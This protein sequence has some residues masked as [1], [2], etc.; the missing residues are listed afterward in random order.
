MAAFVARRHRRRWERATGLAI[1]LGLVAVAVHFAA[2]GASATPGATENEPTT[3]VLD[4]FQRPDEA[5]LRQGGNWA[6]ASIDGSGPTL[7]VLGGSAGQDEG[8]VH[9]DSYRSADLPPGDAEVYG[10]IAVAPSDQRWMQLYLHL[11]EAGTPG[12]D[13]YEVRWFHWVA[14]DG[15]YLRKIV[16]GVSTNLPGSP[17][18]I[19][20]A[21]EPRAGDILLFRRVGGS[22]QFWHK[23]AGTWFLRLSA[24]DSSY[25]G[26]KIGLGTDGTKARWDDFGGSGPGAPPPPPPPP[27]GTP[28]LDRSRGICGGTGV[29]AIATSRCLSDPVNTLTGAFITSADDLSVPGAGIAFAWSRSYTSSD[30]TSGRLGPGWTDGYATSLEIEADGDAR[31]HGDEGQIVAYAKQ[32]DGSFVGAPGSLSVLSAVPGGYQLARTDQVVYRFD[33]VGRLLSTKDRNGQGLTFAYDGAGR[34]STVTDAAGR[35]G[36]LTYNPASLVTGVSTEDGRSVA[37]GYADGRLTSFTDV[38]GKTWR[39]SYDAAGRLATIVD[40]LDH[41]QV[42][43]AYGADGRIQS[44]TDALGK[45]TAFAWD[46]TTQTA[47]ATDANGNAWKDD[48]AENVLVARVDPLGNATEFEHDDGLNMSG[49]TSP[50]GETTSLTHDAHGNVLTATGSASLGGARKSFAYNARNDPTQVTDAR[51]VVTSYAYDSEGNTEGVVQDGTQVASYT[52]D[53]VGRVLTS[54]DGN[55]QTTS[56]T[57]DSNGNVGS[58]TDP[59]GN[60]TTYTYD[61]AGRV[62]SRVDPRGNVAGANPADFTWRW[63]YNA[64]GQVLTERNPLG[65]VTTHTYDDAGNELSVTDA[66]GR[67]TTFAYDAANR[68]TSEEGPAPDAAGPLPARVTTYVYDDVGNR[69]SETDAL[70]RTTT[71]AYD[72]AN[73]HVSTTAPD[74]DG[75]GPLSAPVT[76]SLYDENGN[77][78]STVEPRGNV[79]GA[80]PNDFRT[81][82]TYD[83]A[84]RLLSTT[85][86]L[87]NAATNSYDP[88]GNLVST[89]DANGRATTTAYDGSGRILR[90]TGADGGVTAYTY[91]AVGNRLTRTD[92]NGHVTSYAYDGA[93]QLVAE[94]GPDPDGPGPNGPA[95]TTHTYDPNGNLATTVDA[96]GN[97][98]PTAGDGRTARAYDASNRLVAIDYSDSTPDVAFAYD[99]VGNR[100]SMT[101]GSGTETRAYD[102]LSRLTSVTRGSNTFCVSLRRRRQS[103]ASNVSGRHGDRLLVRR[104][105]PTVRRHRRGPDDELRLRR[106]V[107]PDAD[108]AS[109]GQRPR[110]DAGLR[111]LRP[112][113]GGH[114]PSRVDDACEPRPRSRRSREPHPDRAHRSAH[115]DAVVRVRRERPDRVGVLPSRSLSRLPGS[116]RPLDLRP[117]GESIDRAAALRLDRVHLRRRRP[118]EAGGVDE[119]HVRRQREPGL[120]RLAY[121]HLRPREPHA[122]DPARVDHHDLL[123][124][125]RRRPSPELH[126]LVLVVEDELPVGREPS[127]S[128]GRARAERLR[129]RA[130][131]VRLWCEQDLDDVRLEH[132]LLPL[133]RARLG[134]EPDLVVGLS[135]LDVFLRAVRENPHRTALRRQRADEF[136]EVHGGVPRPDRPLSPARTSVRPH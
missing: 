126:R 97:S 25:Q 99:A 129:L 7:E 4:D 15:L 136:H 106:R 133:R 47:T 14:N 9:G 62:L 85:D 35:D 63:T 71:F 40:P 27:S 78:A 65:G 82:F 53:D 42:T 128:T 108:D 36:T 73:R 12:V 84:G 68:L 100:I 59:L 102:A 6:S 34:L 21:E 134:G 109:V 37:Y 57:Y 46:A 94:T 104:P 2:G 115:A 92:A 31:L 49:V 50:T 18:Q 43:N 135:A 61:D 45:V 1:A 88:V 10:T 91:D 32:P 98:T 80:N 95:V 76:T 75:A 16:D 48:Y 124:R 20:N 105:R 64:A 81:T 103:R 5:P 19:A 55:S 41:V 107:E 77:V 3:T 86:P 122:Y 114:E 8:D 113:H 44:Q 101:D 38:R 87:G 89:R 29:H 33:P 112:A 69:R 72:A 39:Y 74:P 11:Q 131:V 96:N 23:R 90:V 119:L 123:L 111:P 79:A 67:T 52:Y 24:S 54:M 17:F 13:G 70:G 66:N 130:S 118:H 132:E 93:G 26:G 83:A 58:E 60:R 30:P 51:G 121:V 56:F 116:V 120:G 117:G 28:P 22:L 110:R 127:S 125:R